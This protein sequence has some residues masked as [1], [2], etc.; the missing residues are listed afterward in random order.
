MSNQKPE[1]QNTLNNISN[2]IDL[3]GK[4]IVE[5]SFKKLEEILSNKSNPKE[6]EHHYK[7]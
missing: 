6:D 7:L 2:L 4:S 1:F 5:H 3:L